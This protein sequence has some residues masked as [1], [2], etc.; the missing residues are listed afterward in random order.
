[1]AFAGAHHRLLVAVVLVVAIVALAVIV[2]D[3]RLE[4]W[5]ERRRSRRMLM[6]LTDSRLKDIGL[7]R[8]DIVSPGWENDHF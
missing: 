1:M 2:A 5:L 4:A 7:S 3:R 6:D 8:A